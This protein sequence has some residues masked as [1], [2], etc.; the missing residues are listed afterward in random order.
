ML[1]IKNISVGYPGK[2]ILGGVS[3]Q[4]KNG[5]SIALLGLNGTGKSTLLH[6]LAGI[7]P[8]LSGSVVLNDEGVTALPDRERA[9]RMTFMTTERFRGGNWTAGEMVEM[10]R[11]PYTGLLGRLSEHDAEVVERAMQRCGVLE[12]RDMRFDQL[13]DGQRQR[14]L[15]ARAL[16]QD[17]PVVLMDE[18]TSFLDVRGK[19]EVF[20]L[21]A[22]L[23]DRMVVYSTHEIERACES[24]SLC[25]V[26]DD[27][28]AFHSYVPQGGNAVLEVRSL[29]GIKS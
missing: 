28:G 14:V 20:A 1:E 11:Y 18:P 10:G 21:L 7:L 15:I 25:W 5:A 13:S 4:V 23:K 26:I 3:A 22:E 29:M 24:A 12:L 6:S 17:T 9:L 19:D 8:L 2:M 27:K 16:A